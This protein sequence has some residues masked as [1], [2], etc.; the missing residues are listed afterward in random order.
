MKT[1][2]SHPFGIL[3]YTGNP[4]HCPICEMETDYHGNPIRPF[5][6]KKPETKRQYR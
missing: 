2:C 3:K 4:W 5:R 1:K 6:Y